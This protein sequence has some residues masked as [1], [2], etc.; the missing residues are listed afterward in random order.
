MH[1]A[2][3]VLQGRG[4]TSSLWGG[5]H[6]DEALWRGPMPYEGG[7]GQ[8]LLRGRGLRRVCSTLEWGSWVDGLVGP[9]PLLQVSAGGS[10]GH[11][12]IPPILEGEGSRKPH[13]P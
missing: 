5:W 6:W 2:L 9:E 4:G 13:P 7:E 12:C 10:T 11:R 3:S 1:Q 8:S